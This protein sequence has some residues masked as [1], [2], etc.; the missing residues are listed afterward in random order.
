MNAAD[1]SPT[2]DTTSL[3]DRHV[4]LG[5]WLR[6]AA[7]WLPL[8]LVAAVTRLYG[9]RSYPLDPHEATLA[10]DALA[11]VSGSDLSAEGWAQ[12]LPTILAALSFFLFGPGDGAARLPSML[13]GLAIVPALAVLARGVGRTVALAAAV[14]L[15][16]SPTLTLASTRLDGAA[17]LVTLGLLASIV[18]VRWPGRTS[19]TVLGAVLAALPLAHPIGWILALVFLGLAVLRTRARLQ[20]TAYLVTSGLVMLAATSTLLF[21]RP[22]GLATFVTAS[23]SALWHDFLAEPGARW[24]VPLVLLA[25]DEFPILVAAL[26]GTV[27]L[28]RSG[29]PRWLVGLATAMVLF[30]VLFGNGSRA[31][32]A[33]VA[34]ASGMLGAF[35]LAAISTRIPWRAF[36]NRW[37]AA[38]LGMLAI[39]VFIGASLAGRLLAGPQG[40]FFVW[41]AGTISLVLLLLV[42]LWIL[43]NIWLLASAARSTPIVLVL[44]ALLTLAVRDA[45]LV[46]AATSYRP[47]TVLHAGD[48]SPGLVEAI[49]RIR[50]ASTDLTMFQFDPRDPTGGHGLAITLGTNVAQPFVW[51]LRD[52]PH[53]TITEGT[54]LASAAAS[55]QVVIVSPSEQ[56]AVAATRPDLIWQPVPY[57]LALPGSL[58]QPDWGRLAIGLIDPRAWR[59]YLS[60]L[61]YRRVAVP[62]QPESV[63][64]GFSPDVAA[65]AGYPAVP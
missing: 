23:W 51:Y 41:L 1:T 12:P 5:N 61:L 42:A 59:E 25:S 3:L 44:L 22:S 11:V 2:R 60:F 65:L 62:A 50:R 35:G 53:L 30:A 29:R 27:V 4:P 17:L 58:A 26:T 45:M 48:A 63:L 56:A 32:L 38:T 34:A 7:P 20:G 47:G 10:S 6:D 64:V 33:L 36:G 24:S 39:V 55:A 49:D 13:A 43:R 14:L 15:I 9:F 54:M 19:A 8:V 21:T 37:N 31:V 52:F 16:L 57:R 40:S 28:W 18:L 46:N